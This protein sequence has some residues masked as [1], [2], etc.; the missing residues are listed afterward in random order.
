MHPFPQALAERDASTAIALLSPE[1]RF[2]SPVVF[3]EY[4]GRQAVEPILHAIAE[5]F[6]EFRYTDSIVSVDQRDQALRFSATIGT[7]TLEGCD[8]IHLDNDD[9]VDELVVMVRPLS[10]LIAL[11]EAM[12]A[13]LQPKDGASA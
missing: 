10:G 7:R 2:R 9:R 3:G 8:F 6:D 11:A 5:V 13:R 1:V 4:S 12:R